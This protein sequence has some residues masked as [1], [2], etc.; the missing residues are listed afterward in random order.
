MD[1]CFSTHKLKFFKLP[2]EL[3]FSFS[4]LLMSISSTFILLLLQLVL[5]TEGMYF[6]VSSQRKCFNV[7][8]P[9]DTPIVFA[10]EL[11]D[12]HSAITLSL[13][14]GHMAIP[15]MKIKEINVETMGSNHLDFVADNDGYYSL[16]L[17]QNGSHKER[18]RFKLIINYGYDSEYYE[19]LSNEQ[20]FDQVNMEVHRL[21]DQMTM[22][23]NEADFQKHKEISFHIET[24]KMN[25]AALWWPMVQI[26]I[27]IATGIFQV[28]NLKQFF[29]NNKLI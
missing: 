11:M 3:L 5:S 29:K 10:Y 6:L 23:L 25:S 14:Y 16:C 1:S 2:V 20:H 17:E 13:Y 12:S 26:G 18:S 7:E 27:L 19:K 28:Q 4:S 21:N 15:D 9:R 8:Q 22:I 24:E